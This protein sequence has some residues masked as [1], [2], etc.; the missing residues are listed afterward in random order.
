MPL[1]LIVTDG[2]IAQDREQETIDLLSEAFLRW[3]GMTGNQFMIPNVIGHIQVTA[4]GRTFAGLKATPVAIV[5]W[6]VPSFAFTD[7][8]AQLGYV[9][10]ATE[11]VHEMSGGKL[12]KESIWVN[13]THAVDGAWGIAG[14]A[15]SNAELGA[16]A[17]GSAS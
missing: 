6:K 9:A 8:G 13:V 16:L 11:I 7:R 10:E 14:K 17:R 15:L 1:T 2:V 3:H 4:K 12:A 5:E